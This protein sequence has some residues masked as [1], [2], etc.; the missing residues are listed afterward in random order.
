MV[1]ASPPAGGRGNPPIYYKIASLR[2]Q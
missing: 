2:S 1:I